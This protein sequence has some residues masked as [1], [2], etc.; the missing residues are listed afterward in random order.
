MQ[1]GGIQ[2]IKAIAAVACGFVAY[3]FK[4][5]RIKQQCTSATMPCQMAQKRAVIATLVTCRNII[6]YKVGC[7]RLPAN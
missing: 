5:L 2:I 1:A 4:R 6:F 3:V 7:L